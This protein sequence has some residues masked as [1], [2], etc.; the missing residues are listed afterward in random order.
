MKIPINKISLAKG[1]RDGVI[2][3][4]TGMFILSHNGTYSKSYENAEDNVILLHCEY[5][6]PVH[7]ILISTCRHNGYRESTLAR[8]THQHF[9]VRVSKNRNQDWDYSTLYYHL[10]V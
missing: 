2:L 10:C 6:T 4:V 9:V 8:V 3:S 7:N 1:C 5:A